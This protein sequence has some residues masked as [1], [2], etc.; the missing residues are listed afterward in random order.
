MSP[1]VE[2]GESRERHCRGAVV[3]AVREILILATGEERK[4]QSPEEMVARESTKA[5]GPSGEWRQRNPE[6]TEKRALKTVPEPAC[7][8]HRERIGTALPGREIEPGP[9]KNERMQTK[10]NKGKGP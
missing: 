2:A 6:E 9:Q 1:R 4:R 5:S 10:T 8:E 3:R 7:L